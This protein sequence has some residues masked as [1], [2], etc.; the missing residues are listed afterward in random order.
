MVSNSFWDTEASQ[1]SGSDGGTGKISAA[2]KDIAT[3]TSLTTVGLDSPWDFMNDPN[4]DVGSEDIW[5]I[6]AEYN[7]GYPNLDHQSDVVEPAGEGSEASPY[8]IACLAN[9]NWLSQTPSAW[10]S[11]FCQTADIDAQTTLSWD[12][13]AG[14]L[15][16]G[17][18]GDRFAGTYNGN[19]FSISNLFIN[20]PE[21]S[22]IAL[23]GYTDAAHISN[24]SLEAADITG[25]SGAGTL[26]GQAYNTSIVQCSATGSVTATTQTSNSN[27]YAGGLIGRYSAF[28]GNIIDLADCWTDVNV[29]GT[30]NRIGGITGLVLSGYQ[31]TPGGTINI[32]SC[33]ALGSISGV[34][35][36]GGMVGRMEA[37]SSGIISMSNSYSIA[38]ISSS[39]TSLGGLIGA[40]TSGTISSCY[41][42]TESSGMASS[43]VGEGRTAAQ[44]THLN[45]FDTYVG[46]EFDLN[47]RLD[48]DS[49]VNSGYPYLAWQVDSPLFLAPPSNVVA[50]TGEGSVSLSWDTPLSGTPT[51]YNV[52]RDDILLTSSPLIL[53]SYD[54]T[55]VTIG[56]TYRYAITAESTEGESGLSEIVS[57][58]PVNMIT[59]DDPYPADESTLYMPP[60]NLSWSIQLLPAYFTP[61][62]FKVY[63]NSSGVFN[64]EDAYFWVDYIEGQTRYTCSEIL[65]S[66][67][68]ENSTYYWKVIPTDSAP[69]RNSREYRISSAGNSRLDITD[70]PVW[71]FHTGVWEFAGGNG[72]A[73][74][75]YLVASADQLNNV[76]NYPGACFSQIA[77]IDLGLA[78][79]N[80][81]DGWQPIG[82]NLNPFTGTYDGN[83]HTISNLFINRPRSYYVGLFVYVE[84]GNITNLAIE[85]TQVSGGNMVG[86][87]AGAAVS[88]T[89]SNCSVAGTVA[90]NYWVGGLVGGAYSSSTISKCCSR[91]SVSGTDYVGGLIGEIFQ[92]DLTNSYSRSSVSAVQSNSVIGG[93]VGYGESS[94]ISNSYSSGSV[95]VTDFSGGLIGDDWGLTVSNS[96]WDTDTSQQSGSAGGTGKS[97]SDM[98]DIATYTSLATLGLDSAWDFMND[99]NDDTGSEDIWAI[100]AEYNDGYPNLDHQNELGILSAPEPEISLDSITGT[101]TISWE[102]VPAAHSYRVY[103]SE[104]PGALFLDEWTLV[105]TIP[106]TADLSYTE[107]EP[108]ARC[109]YRVIADSA[110]STRSKD[111][112]INK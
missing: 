69:I 28:N 2:M 8:Q 94:T 79:Y 16:I 4:D 41:W 104:N 30:G 98:K 22:G 47:W 72:T 58:V 91:G 97:T 65:D 84:G 75:P 80:S 31:T 67:L 92:S 3:Y 62:G 102:A 52:Y 34:N 93:L 15:P 1:Q 5:A 37:T 21:D 90:A 68:V 86:I 38:A 100:S 24:I 111:I 10:S 12:E 112:R 83:H 64:P 50:D 55:D 66:G 9:L 76:R 35:Q 54:D 107:A 33:Y 27:T 110:V 71:I 109:F 18:D 40:Y 42:D 44:M 39:G 85:S 96:F 7:D 25:R 19:G 48:Y 49:S 74:N 63:L 99:P 26:V 70:T 51:G 59:L 81:D 13:D 89:V 88:T 87:L 95:S 60:A 17:T 29:S 56:T 6:S 61:L 23:F 106:D 36:L 14:F 77:D 20:R 73:D 108:S 103:A 78:P 32:A 105:A 11:F 53:N 43:P 101:L 45:S 46:W 57:I 82:D